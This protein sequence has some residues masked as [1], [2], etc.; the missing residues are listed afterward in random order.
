MMISDFDHQV[1]E[2]FPHMAMSE[3]N[4]IIGT[5]PSLLVYLPSSHFILVNVSARFQTAAPLHDS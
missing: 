3:Y 1:R 5:G 4:V 2:F